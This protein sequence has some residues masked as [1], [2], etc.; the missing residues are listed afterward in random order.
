ML[1]NILNLEGA[2]KLSA[3]EQKGIIGGGPVDPPIKCCVCPGKST[4]VACDSLCPNG[5]IPA[6]VPDCL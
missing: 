3:Y 6:V 2:Q 4:R 5:T 1:K